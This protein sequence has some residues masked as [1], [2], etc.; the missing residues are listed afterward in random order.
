M[1]TTTGVTGDIE[2][3]AAT[4]NTHIVTEGPFQKHVGTDI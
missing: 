4:S 3:T 2:H 1:T